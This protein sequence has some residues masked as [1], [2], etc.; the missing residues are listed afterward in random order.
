MDCGHTNFFLLAKKG[1]RMSC[2][3]IIIVAVVVIAR[4][5]W[6]P[7]SLLN[8]ALELYI[9]LVVA[10]IVKTVIG[11]N[12]L[13]ELFDSQKTLTLSP[14]LSAEHQETLNLL[15]NIATSNSQP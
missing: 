10:L 8:R 11:L 15:P 14:K 1:L 3:V 5:F 9:T 4:K 12:P 7:L 6:L 13:I 2:L